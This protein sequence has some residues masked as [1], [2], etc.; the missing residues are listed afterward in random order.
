MTREDRLAELLERWESAATTGRRPSPEEICKDTP[1]DLPAFKNLLRQLGKAGLVTATGQRVSAVPVAGFRAGRYTATEYHAAGGLGVVYK[2]TDEELNRTVALKCMKLPGG[3]DSPAGRRFFSEAEVTSHLEHP[4]IAP[5]HGR[6]K[7]DDGRPFY[8]MRFI[9]GETLQDATRRFHAPAAIAAGQRGVELRRLLR[10]FVGVCE[11]VAYAHSRGIIHRDLKP[12]NIMVGPFGEV[13]VMDW[14]LAKQLSI[15]DCRLPMESQAPVSDDRQSDFDTP[16]TIGETPELDPTVYGRAKGSP[17]FMSPEQARGDWDSVGIA[18]DIYSLGSTLFYVLTGRVPYDGRTSADVVA[19]VRE[20]RF[21]PPRQINADVPGALDAVCQKAM[22]LD[23]AGRYATAKALAEDIERWLADEPVSA[24]REPLAARVRRWGRRHRTAVTAVAVALVVGFALLAIYGYRLDRKNTQLQEAIAGETAARIHAEEQQELADLRFQL[25]L[26]S[27]SMLVTDIQSKLVRA[28]GTR[29]VRESLLKSAI[30]QLEQLVNRAD[31][32]KDANRTMVWARLRLGDLYRDVEQNPTRAE[33]EYLRALDLVRQQKY[34]DNPLIATDLAETLHRLAGVQVQFGRFS[35]AAS[36]YTDASAA[37]DAAGPLADPQRASNLKLRAEL[38]MELG[39]APAAEH[40]LAEARAIREKLAASPENDNAQIALAEVI[41]AQ[42][43]AADRGGRPKQALDHFNAALDRWRSVQARHPADVSLQRRIALTHQGLAKAHKQFGSRAAATDHARAFFNIT[44]TLAEQDPDND[45]AQL[46]LALAHNALA[47]DA[48]SHFD[49]KSADEHSAQSLAVVQRLS[50]IDPNNLPAR[51][52]YAVAL[53]GL[54]AVARA[55]EK[56]PEAIRWLAEAT[57]VCRDTL[58]ASPD[59]AATIADLAEWLKDL[60]QL[61][62]HR[63]GDPT[64]GLPA[65][66]ESLDKW[67]ALVDADPSSIRWHFGAHAAR[68]VLATWHRK[69]KKLDDAEATYRAGL[70]SFDRLP[71]ADR[72]HGAVRRALGG[73]YK[74]L[75][76]IR[77]EQSK[78]DD[79]IAAAQ[80]EIA[81]LDREKEV[82]PEDQLVWELLDQFHTF[83]ADVYATKRDRPSSDAHQQKAIDACRRALRI[84]PG[85]NFIRRNLQV[86]L[87]YQA[88]AASATDPLAALKLYEEALD[89]SPDYPPDLAETSILRTSFAAM[90]AKAGDFCEMLNRP[91]DALEH[92]QKALDHHTKIAEIE[93][94]GPGIPGVIAYDHR[95]M[96]EIRLYLLDFDGAIADY[97]KARDVLDRVRADKRPPTLVDR[98]TETLVKQN[99]PFVESL[100]K[101]IETLDAALKQPRAVRLD[102][103]RLRITWLIKHGKLDDAAATAERMAAEKSANGDA[104]AR[105]AVEFARLSMEKSPKSKEHAARAIELLRKAKDAGYFRGPEDKAWLNWEPYFAPLRDDA[106]FRELVK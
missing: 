48:V 23:P 25:A 82:R 45:E 19:R 95:R 3:I 40:L 24:W 80:R 91:K 51:Q 105:A 65:L 2:A 54:G 13:L 31:E 63:L 66:T 61:Y 28:P 81:S 9:E 84:D 97:R 69:Q 83:L 39:D 102:A 14:G 12:S 29:A 53:H 35:K 21:T 60:G 27:A 10:E 38:A 17:S 87:A 99:L 67:Q 75:A 56:T 106:A 33:R 59:R 18:S 37:I 64:R 43:H 16:P 32:T 77:S 8:A 96:A 103:L 89:H 4:G 50:R 92:Y 36:L 22:A 88:E 44:R 90:G 104:F 46:A 58:K 73:L 78:T 70:Q 15:V 26:G 34:P 49:L 1:E 72:D 30:V 55:R 7:T 57:D 5:V 20:G 98:Q 76:A 94:N 93:P 101:A 62:L 100:P 11:T 52:R 71:A 86:H 6:G 85:N 79:A 74:E 41:T 42:G 68:M 47:L